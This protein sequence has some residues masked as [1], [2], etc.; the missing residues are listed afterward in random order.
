M[1]PLFTLD[2]PDSGGMGWV[3]A[4]I[5]WPHVSCGHV[6]V[7]RCMCTWN[8]YN[9]VCT[10]LWRPRTIVGVTPRVSSNFFLFFS[11]S[12][13]LTELKP[14]RLAGPQVPGAC[15]LLLLQH[16][17]YKPILSHLDFLTWALEIKLRSLGLPFPS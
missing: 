1:C 4:F 7:C 5:L 10:C 9:C 12:A 15:L 14:P 3:Y 13:S 8:T 2:I 17:D 6:C 11:E 16:L